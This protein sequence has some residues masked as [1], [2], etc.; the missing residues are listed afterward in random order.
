MSVSP[1]VM[2]LHWLWPV[3]FVAGVCIC[4]CLS[5]VLYT[6]M[7]GGLGVYVSVVCVSYMPCSISIWLCQHGSH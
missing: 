1:V 4:V 2:Q 3:D 5:V 6:G 7:V